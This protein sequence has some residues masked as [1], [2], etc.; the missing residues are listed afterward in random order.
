MRYHNWPLRFD[1]FVKSRKHMPFQW[2]VND[3]SL[4]AADCI[5]ALTGVDHAG[6]GLR[7]YSSAKQAYRLL[8]GLG[9]LHGV[10]TLALGNPLPIKLAQIGDVVLCKSNTHDMLAI[11]NGRLAIAPGPSGIENVAL[12]SLCWRVA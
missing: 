12:G 9:G 6:Q 4:F 1:E 10:A 3:C 11:C 5:L 7:T 2:G 8:Q